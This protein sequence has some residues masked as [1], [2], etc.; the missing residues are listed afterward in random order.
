MR[1]AALVAASLLVA[2]CSH[3]TDSRGTQPSTSASTPSR[4]TST[5][6][7]NRP[8]P[9]AA[10]APSAGAPISDVIA[11]VEAGAPADA[12]TYHR[13][14]R[15][16]VTADLGT[17]I[18]FKVAKVRC[19]TDTKHTGGA[20]SCLVGLAHPPPRPATVYGQW[21]GGWVDF[22]GASLQ[23]GSAHA[24]PGPFA[25]GDGADL[26]VGKS[27]FFGDYRCRAD[28]VGVYCVN[29]AH[30]SAAALAATGIE[31]FGCLQAVPPPEGVGQKFSC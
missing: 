23:V 2:G 28:Q 16:G 29:Y 3:A 30:R 27:L 1:I 13:V 17:D 20:L 22:D 15:D 25:R 31:P 18:A 5:T 24:D 8:P 6:P 12:G 4:A 19:M 10:V 21:Q 7:S 14:T 26:P 11:W 9:A